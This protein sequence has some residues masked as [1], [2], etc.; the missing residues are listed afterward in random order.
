M[1]LK[2][3]KD[4]GSATVSSFLL[5]CSQAQARVSINARTVW[6]LFFPRPAGICST[7]QMELRIVPATRELHWTVGLTQPDHCRRVQR[8]IFAKEG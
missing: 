8:K 3:F 5:S 2:T 7:L 6:T 1:D 4:R